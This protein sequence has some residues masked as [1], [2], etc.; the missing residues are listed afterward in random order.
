MAR[1]D[2]CYEKRQLRI[3][4]DHKLA[5]LKMR[6]RRQADQREEEFDSLVS[7]AAKLGTSFAGPGGRAARELIAAEGAGWGDDYTKVW[8][9]GMAVIMLEGRKSAG[10]DD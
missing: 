10:G 3:H 7:V 9:G 6:R 8:R 4:P 2:R 5:A 1:H